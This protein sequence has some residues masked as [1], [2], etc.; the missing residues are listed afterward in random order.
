MDAGD[1]GGGCSAVHSLGRERVV[2]MA[3]H[4]AHAAARALAALG[5]RFRLLA[6][7]PEYILRRRG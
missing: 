5:P 6:S 1:E 7:V 2:R 4:E 3:E